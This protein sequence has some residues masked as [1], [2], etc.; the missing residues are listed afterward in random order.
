M[1]ELP[2][3]ARGRASSVTT[4][5][6]AKQPAGRSWARY[7]GDDCSAVAPAFNIVT[8]RSRPLAL[9]L[10][11]GMVAPKPAPCPRWPHALAHA[12]HTT[13]PICQLD[14]SATSTSTG[15]AGAATSAENRA[16]ARSSERPEGDIVRSIAVVDSTD[17]LVPL[18]K[19]RVAAAYV[20][21]EIGPMQSIVG[22]M[23]QRA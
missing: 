7:R 16:A 1:L 6:V 10:G 15:L 23:G 2:V 4:P 11:L 19:T 8:P 5:Y 21:G 22:R 20:Q 12:R 3:V 14:W 17:P 13:L 18:P 9:L